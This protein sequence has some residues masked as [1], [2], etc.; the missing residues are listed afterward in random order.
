MT[1]LDLLAEYGGL[2]WGHKAFRNGLHT[3]GWVE[4]GVLIREPQQLDVVAATQASQIRAAFPETTLLVGA[5]ACGA[6]LAAF[7]AR[8][9]GLPVAFVQGENTGLHWHR[10][11]VP[12]APQPVVVVDDL[13]CTGQGTVQIADF[14]KAQGHTVLGVSAWLSRV[15]LHLP[16]ITMAQTPFQTYTASEYPMCQQSMPLS[17]EGIRE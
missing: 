4:K 17:Y 15:K 9:L 14:L 8:H 2:F 13:L 5:P 7:V 6:V 16:L 10:M 11:S 1:P 12:A 3:D